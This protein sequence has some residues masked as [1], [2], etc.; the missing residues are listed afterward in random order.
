MRSS[1]P[2]P[3]C[4]D[5]KQSNVEQA[6]TNRTSERPVA[7]TLRRRLVAL[8]PKPSSLART[9]QGHKGQRGKQEQ[10]GLECGVL[11]VGFEQDGPV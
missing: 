6:K 2:Y 8:N 11:A 4:N 7:P 10:H 5:Y 3:T 9:G 1:R